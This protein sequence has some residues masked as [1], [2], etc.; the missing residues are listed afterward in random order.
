MCQD[1]TKISAENFPFVEE[2]NEPNLFFNELD[3]PEAE[4]VGEPVERSI[5]R[6][7][8]TVNDRGSTIISFIGTILELLSKMDIENGFLESNVSLI[9]RNT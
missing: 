8:K 2:I 1:M 7:D 9:L 6:F 3:I 4:C 5:G